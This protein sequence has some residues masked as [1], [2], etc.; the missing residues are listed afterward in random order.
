M[1]QRM[2][3]GSSRTRAVAAFSERAEAE[4]VG[5]RWMIESCVL[6]DVIL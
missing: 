1:K 2:H 4:L 3:S 5:D 6:P